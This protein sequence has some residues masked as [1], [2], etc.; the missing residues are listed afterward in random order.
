MRLNYMLLRLSYQSFTDFIVFINTSQSITSQ[1]HHKPSRTEKC[2]PKNEFKYNALEK[3][4]FTFR[5]RFIRGG[6][7]ISLL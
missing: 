2:D 4:E 1:R 5:A 7:I 3:L 6:L